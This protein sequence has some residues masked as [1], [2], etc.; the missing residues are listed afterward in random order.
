MKKNYLLIISIVLTTGLTKLAAQSYRGSE[1]E[2]LQNNRAGWIQ[3]KL[4]ASIITFSDYSGQVDI[5]AALSS[6]FVQPADRTSAV[7]T[8]QDTLADFTMILDK[9]QIKQQ[10]VTAGKVF[11]TTGTL[12]MNGISKKIDA[13]CQLTP[14]ND[15]ANGFVIS[16][17]IRFNPANFGMRINGETENDALIVRVTNGY[18]NPLH[19]KY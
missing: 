19:D 8:A 2:A 18:L 15:P 7:S 9:E 13:Q 4:P 11:T 6:L 1:T 17:V 5:K 14:R 10:Q 3:K 16:V 12:S